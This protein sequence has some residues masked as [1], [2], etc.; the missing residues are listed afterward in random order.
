M[1]KKSL[2]KP[3]DSELEILQI[4]WQSGPSTVKAVNEKLNEKKETG[5][6]TTLKL[7]QIMYEKE[8][9]VR[10]EEERSHVY[11]AAI[12]EGDIQKALVDRLLESAFSGSATKLVMQA[13]GNSQT[14]KEELEQ[15][16]AYLTEIEKGKR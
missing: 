14:S 5:Y 1:S 4:L 12:G 6:T 2:L 7:L 3:T 11:S 13:I 16:R 9:V 15:I 10:N 8:I